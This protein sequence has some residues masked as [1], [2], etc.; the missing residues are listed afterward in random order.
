MMPAMLVLMS[1]APCAADIGAGL[2]RIKTTKELYKTFTLNYL[3]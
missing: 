1:K 2:K 3:V